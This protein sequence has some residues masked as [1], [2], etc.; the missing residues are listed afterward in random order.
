[1]SV[2]Q[3]IDKPL[4]LERAYGHIGTFNNAETTKN[5]KPLNIAKPK[6]QDR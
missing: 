6:I 3:R 4:F 2:F 1:L 5:G